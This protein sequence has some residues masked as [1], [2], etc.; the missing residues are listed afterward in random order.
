MHAKKKNQMLIY[1]IYILDKIVKKEVP[2]PY[3]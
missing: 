3:V 1:V 2:V